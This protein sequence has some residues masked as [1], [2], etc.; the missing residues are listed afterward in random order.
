MPVPHLAEALTRVYASPV[1]REA[2]KLRIER[3]KCFL[4][5]GHLLCGVQLTPP[6][7]RAPAL[8]CLSRDRRHPRDRAVPLH[9]PRLDA[10]LASAHE[11]IRLRPRLRL[12][13]AVRHVLSP[14]GRGN[15]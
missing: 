9:S 4:P 15:E 14:D 2:Q 3:E 8:P 6:V 13:R 10:L 5:A 12:R 11:A 1:R 7:R